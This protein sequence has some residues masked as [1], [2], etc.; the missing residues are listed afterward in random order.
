MIRKHYLTFHGAKLASNEVYWSRVE[1][2]SKFS[3]KTHINTKSKEIL[4]D[5][6]NKKQRR[7]E[8]GQREV[9]R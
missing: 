7:K 9:L 5:K 6:A 4:N 1:K 8:R 3:Q 2:E